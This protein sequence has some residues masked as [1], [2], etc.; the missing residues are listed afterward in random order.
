[1]SL[2]L[3]KLT[4]ES[5]ILNSGSSNYDIM[6]LKNFAKL[7]NT[8][9][10]TNTGINFG[11]NI[12]AYIEEK[13]NS[14]LIIFSGNED[15]LTE[16]IQEKTGLTDYKSCPGA[17]V[18]QGFY[19]EFFPARIYIVSK[20]LAFIRSDNIIPIF[21]G[22]SLGGVYAILAA[23]ALHEDLP[24]M[25][26]INVYTY[27][28]PRIGNKEFAQYADSRLKISRATYFNDDVPT[29][30]VAHTILWIWGNAYMHC[31]LEYYIP[32]P[33][34]ENQLRRCNSLDATSE[35]KNCIN[36]VKFTSRNSHYGPYWGIQMN[37]CEDYQRD[38][39][40]D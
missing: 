18:N 25:L 24:N 5:E 4:D 19:E 23:L 17:K 20:I 39:P 9:Y 32:G 8:A 7:A 33:K 35:S 31:G 6:S 26:D 28:I 3:G 13:D 37:K 10:C 40:M 22:H 16:F 27:G 15:D 29:K 30:P 2:P 34:K 36:A 38:L 1:M 11:P 21:I 14:V 12:Q